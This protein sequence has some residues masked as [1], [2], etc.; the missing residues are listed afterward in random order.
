M[1]KKIAWK[2]YGN[3]NIGSSRLRAF[4]PCKYLRQEGWNCEI[5]APKK[6]TKYSL[7][8]FQKDYENDYCL[9]LAKFLKEKGIKVVV[10]LCDNDFYNPN[11]Y[12]WIEEKSERLKR[13]ID[14]ADAVSVSTPE[15]AKLVHGKLV[16]V[17]DDVIETP[18]TSIL[19]SLLLNLKNSFTVQTNS[20]L[21][22]VWYGN[23]RID[24]PESP[25]AGIIDIAAI[26]PEL[27]ALHSEVS[28][29]L[30]VIS[31]SKSLFDKYLSSVSFPT[32]YYDWDIKT[33][34]H[35]FR[36]HDVCIIPVNTNPFTI[37]KTN[38]RLTL[39]LLLEVP[40]VADRIPSYEEF[41]DFVLWGDWKNNLLK[42]A[43]NL[44][45]RKQHISNGKSY[46]LGHFN[47]ERV[48]TQWSNLFNN[49]LD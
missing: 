38:N 19:N 44:E 21:K 48:V 16:Y 47:K 24:P 25:A 12:P 3:I 17:I 14:I 42:Y 11:N 36:Q 28:I 10:D 31:S 39:S 7:V 33:F 6:V 37:C 23:N 4:I 43:T 46:I 20:S 9:E 41:S 22:I 15:L 1:S 45:L 8:I 35:L 13:L 29:S 32:Q 30:T 34:P 5:Y 27:E 18:S 2:P 49:L 26:I 40:V